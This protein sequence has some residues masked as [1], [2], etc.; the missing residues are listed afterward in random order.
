MLIHYQDHWKST[1]LNLFFLYTFLLG[2]GAFQQSKL[3]FSILLK[4]IENLWKTLKVHVIFLSLKF[5]SFLPLLFNLC[6]NFVCFWKLY[7]DQSLFLDGIQNMVSKF[8]T[9][10]F[11]F[12]L[13][14]LLVVKLFYTPLSNVYPFWYVLS[15]QLRMTVK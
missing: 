15:F 10:Y 8:T 1:W 11:R 9:S 13:R 4:L 3:H 12:E 2:N 7:N 5:L 6:V 14:Y